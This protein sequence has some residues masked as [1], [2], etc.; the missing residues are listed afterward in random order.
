MRSSVTSLHHPFR[1]KQT[2]VTIR[3]MAKP[4]EIFSTKTQLFPKTAGTR[5]RK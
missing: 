5:S 3:I 1:P 2:E 4:Y